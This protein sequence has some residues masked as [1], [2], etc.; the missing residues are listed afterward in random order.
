MYACETPHKYKKYTDRETVEREL[1]A[2][3]KKGKA[4]KIDSSTSNLYFIQP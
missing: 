4:R 3:L 2:Y 1:N